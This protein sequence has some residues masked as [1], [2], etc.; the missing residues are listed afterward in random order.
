ML[1][2]RRETRRKQNIPETFVEISRFS[3]DADPAGKRAINKKKQKTAQQNIIKSQSSARQK[4]F[5]SL[6]FFGVCV[7]HAKL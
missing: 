7:E 3:A 1:L 4:V 6:L 5:A 2:L